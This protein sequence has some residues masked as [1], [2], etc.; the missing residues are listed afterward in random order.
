[1]RPLLLLLLLG[2]LACAAAQDPRDALVEVRIEQLVGPSSSQP[3]GRFQVQ[4][5]VEVRNMR[6]EPVTVR[7]IEMR[8]IGGGAYLLLRTNEFKVFDRM[9]APGTTDAVDFWTEAVT[10]LN[11][12]DPG[13]GEPVTIR[14]TIFFDAPSGTFRKVAHQRFVMD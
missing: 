4:Y 14:M 12:G 8:Q 7:R 11:Q 1:M 13:A 6:D 2:G 10:R 9:I 3:I 5:G